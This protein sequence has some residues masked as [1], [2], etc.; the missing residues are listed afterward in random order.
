MR[1]SCNRFSCE[2]RVCG[3]EGTVEGG[4]DSIEGSRELG[5]FQTKETVVSVT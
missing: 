2:G 3:W 1:V 4:H 5:D